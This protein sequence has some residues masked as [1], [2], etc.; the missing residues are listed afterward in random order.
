MF[1]VI[2]IFKALGLGT[3]MILL[4]FFTFSSF[5]PVQEILAQYFPSF[6]VLEN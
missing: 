6:V 1:L 2:I 3:S 5:V 4:L